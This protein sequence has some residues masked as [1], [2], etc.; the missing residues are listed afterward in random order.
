MNCYR[1]FKGI[2]HLSAGCGNGFV[3]SH[4]HVG[5]FGYAIAIEV[6]FVGGEIAELG[7]LGLALVGLV[8]FG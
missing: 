5:A 1:Y 4:L 3:L 6:V 8:L 7:Y 2:G